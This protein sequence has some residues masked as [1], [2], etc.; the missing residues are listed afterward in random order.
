MLNGRSAAI[1]TSGILTAVM[2]VF[3]CPEWLHADSWH[4]AFVHHFFHANLFHLA[5]NCL[6]LWLMLRLPSARLDIRQIV[7]AY[8]CASVSWYFATRDVVGASNFIFA[9]AGLR[10]P[11]FRSKWWRL[12]S[13]RTFLVVTVLMAVFPQVSAV[14]HVISFGL[15]CMCSAVTRTLKETDHDLVRISSH[16]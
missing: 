11:S 3:R 2:L 6:S 9:F 14:T 10:T 1:A 15:G 5:A 8:I 13:V 12:Q 4:V 16:R 7:T